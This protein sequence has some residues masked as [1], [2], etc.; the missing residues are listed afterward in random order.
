MGLI[1]LREKEARRIEKNEPSEKYVD[2]ASLALPM[3][4]RGTHERAGTLFA[5]VCCEKFLAGF[6]RRIVSNVSWF[7]FFSS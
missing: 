2:V 7:V 4:A 5:S 6:D 3:T 1:K